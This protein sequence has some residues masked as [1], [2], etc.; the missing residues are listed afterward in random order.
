MSFTLTK[1][2]A[3]EIQAKQIEHYVSVYGE[4]VRQAVAD[5]TTADELADDVGYDV[6]TIN[7]H[8]PRGGAIEALIP[9][10]VEA[11]RRYRE[12]LAQLLGGEG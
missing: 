8:I 6:V 3:L 1:K 5:A 11:E 4:G 9:A 10:K 7:R 12:G 2:E